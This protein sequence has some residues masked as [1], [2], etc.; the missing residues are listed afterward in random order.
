[1]VVCLRGKNT[2]YICLTVTFTS[3]L[4]Y[5]TDAFDYAYDIFF[6]LIF[7]MK[8]GYKVI[9][10]CVWRWMQQ[11]FAL[12]SLAPVFLVRLVRCQEK[13][14]S[15]ELGKSCS[16]VNACVIGSLVLWYG[17][18]FK[19]GFLEG[20]KDMGKIGEKSSKA[21]QRYRQRQRHSVRR[22]FC[23][24]FFVSSQVRMCVWEKERGRS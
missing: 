22:A 11:N 5:Y 2:F 3:L 15:F 9:Q 7:Y 23:V 17:L 19:E 20:E 21:I 4:K 8:K 16:C 14:L 10:E 6:A 18:L 1:M 13:L 12:C 24:Y